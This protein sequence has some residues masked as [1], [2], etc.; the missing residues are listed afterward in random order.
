[1]GN[2]AEKQ[3]KEADERAREADFDGIY[4]RS[5]AKENK[6]GAIKYRCSCIW[7]NAQEQRYFLYAYQ[8]RT[9]TGMVG[10]PRSR[11][12][13]TTMMVLDVALG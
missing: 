8:F 13:R 9:C 4:A 10:R 6:S 11:M 2:E 7:G 5:A 12:R 1:M 3:R